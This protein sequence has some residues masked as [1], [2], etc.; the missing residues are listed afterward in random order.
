MTQKGD[1][2]NVIEFLYDSLYSLILG[3]F[4]DML[5]HNIIY[6]RTQCGISSKQPPMSGMH[7]KT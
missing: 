3:L 4:Y 5:L 7:P 6:T 1:E 2:I